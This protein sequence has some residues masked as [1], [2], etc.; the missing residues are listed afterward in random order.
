MNG[1][2]IASGVLTQ[3]DAAWNTADGAA[4]ADDADVVNLFGMHFRSREATA[5]RMQ[6]IFEMICRESSHR[7]RQPRARREPRLQR[8]GQPRL[9]AWCQARSRRWQAGADARHAWRRSPPPYSSASNCSTSARNCGKSSTMIA[10]TT[11]VTI[12]A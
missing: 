3:L 8:H 9:N 5:A 6:P 4:F 7:R 11:S 1:A 12:V 10:H 2:W